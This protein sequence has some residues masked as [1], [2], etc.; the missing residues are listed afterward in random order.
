MRQARWSHCPAPGARGEMSTGDAG[1]DNRSVRRRCRPQR[2]GIQHRH[3]TWLVVALE[4]L[5]L[6]GGLAVLNNWRPSGNVAWIAVVVGIHFFALARLWTSG[7]FEITVIAFTADSRDAI[8]LVSGVG[9][10][11]VLL[12]SSLSAI[13]RRRGQ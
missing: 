11:A 1:V 12:T 7:S 5:T 8:A 6:F 10:G 2:C 3:G 9:S 4:S 13:V